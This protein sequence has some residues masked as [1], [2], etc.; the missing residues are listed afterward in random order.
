MRK[1]EHHAEFEPPDLPPVILC[2]QTPHGWCGLTADGQ[3]FNVKSADGYSITIPLGENLRVTARQDGRL[4]GYRAV[5]SVLTPP[6]LIA[7]YKRQCDGILEALNANRP[8]VAL[9]KVETAM[10]FAPT[11]AARHSRALIL[12]E[13][14]RWQEGW[15]EYAEVIDR[16]QTRAC[17]ELG[18]PR[19]RGE[20]I[21]GKRLMLVHDHGFG[22]SI[23]MLR[24]VPRLREIG[25]DV[26]LLMPSELERLASQMAPVVREAVDC[27]YF[28]SDLLLLNVLGETPQSIPLAPYLKP[29]PELIGKWEQRVGC[30][31]R[32]TVGVAWLAGRTH[33]VDYPRQIELARL[34]KALPD[35]H[36]ISIQKQGGDEA[37]VFGVEHFEIGDFA[38]CAALIS[39]LDEIVTIDTAAVHLAGA[40]GHPR[41]TLLLG[42]WA[43]WRW[44]SPLYQ[45]L[46]IRQQDVPDNWASAWDALSS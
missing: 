29:E 28:S 14:G 26:V 11:T 22:D 17:L 34:V 35:K 33:G 5:P 23:M 9:L 16:P 27:D 6:G 1:I 44:L 37:D 15:S 12:L 40:I 7:N 18:L 42:H 39:I 4:I 21:A 45:N 38:D 8:D 43:S 46:L 10:S 20:D 41:T 25:A 3:I 30:K 36:L 2:E 24:Y 32:K 31:D 19:W 13:L